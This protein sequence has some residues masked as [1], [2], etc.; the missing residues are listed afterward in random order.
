MRSVRFLECGPAKTQKVRLKK[1]SLICL[2]VI[3]M[4]PEHP[5]QLTFS[6]LLGK[7]GIDAG[8]KHLF[9]HCVK[10]NH[11]DNN[12]DGKWNCK[13]ADTVVEMDFNVILIEH[14]LQI[15]LTNSDS[16]QVTMSQSGAG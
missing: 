1:N 12:L 4:L 16:R 2:I 6:Q 8:H 10:Y 9:D 7:M 3:D 5:N 13:I 14:S 15:T 11:G